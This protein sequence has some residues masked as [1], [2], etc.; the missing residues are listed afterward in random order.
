MFY[1]YI[2]VICDDNW[3]TSICVD[4]NTGNWERTIGYLGAI[5]D[6]VFDSM[7]DN[8]MPVLPGK[9]IIK[10]VFENNRV[11]ID[12]PISVELTKS[13]I[14]RTIE[15]GQEE[16]IKNSKLENGKSKND[17]KPKLEK[18]NDEKFELEEKNDEK[19]E[20]EERN[21]EKFKLDVSSDNGAERIDC[22]IAF[23]PGDYEKCIVDIGDLC[24]LGKISG[25][26]TDYRC[27][28]EKS[29][30][31]ANAWDDDEYEG[32]YRSRNISYRVDL[33]SGGC[34]FADASDISRIIK[35][36][37]SYVIDYEIGNP[38]IVECGNNIYF[39]TMITG[40]WKQPDGTIHYSVLYDKEITRFINE[41]LGV[42]K[43][44]HHHVLP[45]MITKE[46]KKIG[47]KNDGNSGEIKKI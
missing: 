26:M 40:V 28:G 25:M 10:I 17:E 7:P 14:V 35:G 18:K 30:I 29:G 6:K 32:V 24:G 34:C 1:I 13:A 11:K 20:L 39:H 41:K 15:L 27:M 4:A 23:N 42:E 36:K 46:E 5:S 22:Y 37:E 19:P 33:P 8:K 43:F 47:L 31:N 38:V 21:D 12:T 45:C 2:T 44:S 3:K 16:I 9:H